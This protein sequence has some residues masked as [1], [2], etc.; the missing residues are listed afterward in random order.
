VGT[1]KVFFNGVQAANGAVSFGTMTNTVPAGATTGPISITTSN[2]THTTLTLFYL[3]PVITGFSPSNSPAGS[4]IKISG[5]NFIDASAVSFNGSPALAFWVT[6]NNTIGAVIPA[7]LATGPISVTT[8]AGTATSSGRFY[9]PLGITGFTPTS[10][11][12]GTNVT[13]FGSNFLGVNFVLFGEVPAV[14]TATNNTFLTAIVPPGAETGPITVGGP[15]GT[16][17]STAN[18]VLNYTSDVELQASDSPDPVNVGSTLVYTLIVTNRGPFSAP[19]FR[20]TNLLDES[21]TLKGVSISQGSW[22]NF[23]GDITVN[24]GTLAANQ[25]ATLLISVIPNSPGTITNR[26]DIASDYPDP[27]TANNAAILTTTVLPLPILHI[28]LSATNRVRL[29]WPAALSNYTLQFRPSLDP[30]VFWSNVVRTPT[31][32]GS[33]RVLTESTS[34]SASFYRLK[35]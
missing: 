24:F 16:N 26:T 14:F 7:G 27:V 35:Q 32:V 31:V 11:L 18:F 9:G 6:N 15:G 4:I 19:N 8:P 20:V 12:P 17:V 23:N 13:V 29:S 21:V 34:N 1:P 22:T 25:W 33:E 3:P 28:Q 2:G 5:T 10:G 30:G